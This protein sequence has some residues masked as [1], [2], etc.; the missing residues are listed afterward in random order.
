MKFYL[1]NE[2]FLIPRNL[3]GGSFARERVGLPENIARDYK[4]DSNDNRTIR[5]KSTERVLVSSEDCA[6]GFEGV[7][8][9]RT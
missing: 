4:S 2:K 6:A 3:S 9:E 1:K 7:Q 5:G 8:L